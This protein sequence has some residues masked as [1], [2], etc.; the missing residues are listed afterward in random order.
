MPN[1]ALERTSYRLARS[2]QTPGVTGDVEIE[3]A[4]STT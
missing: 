3:S 2:P 1:D 4:C